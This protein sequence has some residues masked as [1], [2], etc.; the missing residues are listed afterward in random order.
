[1]D[2]RNW[3]PTETLS[4]QTM[5]NFEL[6]FISPIKKK[7]YIPHTVLGLPSDWFDEYNQPAV[8]VVTL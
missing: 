5:D 3:C 1:M 6:C 4:Y 2:Q 7:K 8:D